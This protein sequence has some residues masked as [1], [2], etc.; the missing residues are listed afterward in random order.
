MVLI[1]EVPKLDKGKSW[2]AKDG[3]NQLL[4][5]LVC[6]CKNLYIY[7]FWGFKYLDLLIHKYSHVMKYL[8]TLLLDFCIF[9]Y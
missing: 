6:L 2:G 1:I 7:I 8:S 5:L 4:Y 9:G 3:H